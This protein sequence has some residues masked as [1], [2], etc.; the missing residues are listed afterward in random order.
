M[1]M[2]VHFLWSDVNHSLNLA[3]LL[4]TTIATSEGKRKLHR[5]NYT[6]W[7]FN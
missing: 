7:V 4:F 1:Q 3:F 5:E 6:R 2:F